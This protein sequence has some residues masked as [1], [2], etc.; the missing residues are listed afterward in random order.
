MTGTIRKVLSVIRFPRSV[1]VNPNFRRGMKGVND[2]L[3][4]DPRPIILIMINQYEPKC[5]KFRVKII[6]QKGYK[7]KRKFR[8]LKPNIPR[9]KKSLKQ[10]R[11]SENLFFYIRIKRKKENV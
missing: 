1:I 8:P 7:Y 6:L 4:R 5:K 10:K 3:K 9:I 11:E 2:L